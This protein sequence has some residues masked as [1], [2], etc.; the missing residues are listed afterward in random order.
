MKTPARPGPDEVGSDPSP[1]PPCLECLR[2]IWVK[3][4]YHRTGPF[5]DK[6]ERA[7]RRAARLI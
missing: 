7:A 1:N 2:K 3:R 4:F 6:R 5:R